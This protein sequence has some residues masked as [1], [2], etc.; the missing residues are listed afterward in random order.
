LY[1]KEE[2]NM[3]YLVF[4]LNNVKYVINV[5]LIE[6]VL[7]YKGSLLRSCSFP[8][9]IGEIEQNGEIIPIIDLNERLGLPPN[10]RTKAR[11]IIVFSS[12]SGMGIPQLLGAIVDWV[13]EVAPATV[14]DA[15]KLF[16]PEEIEEYSIAS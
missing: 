4:I 7:A 10:D 13:C 3:Q 12:D 8:S 5:S 9:S 1:K 11:R 15:E 6:S 14:V 2:F 16:T